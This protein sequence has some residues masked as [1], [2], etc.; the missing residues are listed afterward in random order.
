MPPRSCHAEMRRFSDPSNVWLELTPFYTSVVYGQAC[1]VL[2]CHFIPWSKD[3]DNGMW[4]HGSVTCPTGCR[5]RAFNNGTDENGTLL[6]ANCPVPLHHGAAFGCCYR[7][8]TQLEKASKMHRVRW[9]TASSIAPQ[10][11][12]AAPQAHQIPQPCPGQG[13]K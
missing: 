6:P 13:T 2:P 8:A 1:C 11:C 5:L 3:G 7:K 12:A 10:C 9:T 4:R